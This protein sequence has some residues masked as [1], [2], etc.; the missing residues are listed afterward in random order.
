[1]LNDK[2]VAHRR[3]RAWPPG[4]R[5]G[6]RAARRRL[7]GRRARWAAA[8]RRP[9]TA[10]AAVRAGLRDRRRRRGRRRRRPASWATRS[11]ATPLSALEPAGRRR[12]LRPP[13]AP[14]LQRHRGGRRAA[15]PAV[16]VPWRAR[17][18]A[19]APRAAQLAHAPR[20][21][22]VRRS[23]TTQRPAYHAAASIASNFLVALEAAA[24]ERGRA[25]GLAPRRRAP[26]SPRS[27]APRSRTGPRSAR[28][29]ALTGPVARGDEATVAAQRA[30]V[31]EAAPSSSALRRDGGARPRA[32][33]EATVPRMRTVRSVAELR[34]ALAPARAAGADRASCPRWAPSTTATC[35]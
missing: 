30:A 29:R 15:S 19:A 20:H 11:G 23:P 10:I 26:R 12:A 33:A 28:A 3:G 22:A 18:R 27:C 2:L 16:D 32:R 1:M 7:R 24:E 21:G 13:P 14:D 4:Q 17:R 25:A 5:A 31:R 8:R 6:R 34:E 35:R 9:A